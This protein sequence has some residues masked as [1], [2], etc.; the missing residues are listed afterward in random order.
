MLRMNR[1]PVSSFKFAGIQLL[2]GADK[3][4][5][6]ARATKKIAEAAQNGAKMISLPECWNCPYSN[7]AFPEYAESIPDGPSSKLLSEQAKEHFVWLI[8]GSIPE[9]VGDKLYNTC[10]VFN[11]QGE[12]VVKH[13]KVHLFDISVPPSD[14]KPGIT[15]KE[16]D[17]LSA[18]SSLSS[19]DTEY[20]KVG[21]GICY[22]IRFPELAIVLAKQGVKFMCYPGAFNMTTGPLHWELLQRARAVD[23]QVYVAAVSPARNPESGYQAWGHSSVVDPWGTVIA[24]TEH[25]EDIIYADIDMEQLEKFR[26]QIPVTKQKRYDLYNIS[27]A[28]SNNNKEEVLA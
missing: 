19:F 25:E 17:T 23:N 27:L 28:T 12:P 9:R 21:V 22:D 11:P 15:F 5:N 18:G 6:H 10:V 14:G 8:G 16:S 2:V 1:L 4:A 26:A 13:R 24:T 3:S 7:A 20:G